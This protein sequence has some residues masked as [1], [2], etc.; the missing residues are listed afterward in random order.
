MVIDDRVWSLPVE[1]TD[2]ADLR[3]KLTRGEEEITENK[4]EYED[5]CRSETAVQTFYDTTAGVLFIVKP[6]GVV[7]S[8]RIMYHHESLLQV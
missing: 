4:D 6:C 7:V 3:R 2:S 8:Q 5:G 1:A